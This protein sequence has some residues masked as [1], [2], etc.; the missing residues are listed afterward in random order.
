MGGRYIEIY[1]SDD[2]EFV[3]AQNSQSP[4]AKNSYYLNPAM[5]EQVDAATGIVHLKNLPLAA[6]ED[7]IRALFA[8]FQ[9]NKPNCIKR[10]I[11]NGKPSGE[12]FVLFESEEEAQNSL[13][14][15]G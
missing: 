3:A 2:K 8:G 5:M 7:D 10:S 6:T 14:R 11:R 13:E 1:E 12:A 4:D 9:L 15:N